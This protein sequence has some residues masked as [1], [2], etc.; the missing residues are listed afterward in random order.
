MR[1]ILCFIVMLQFCAVGFSDLDSSSV[2][3]YTSP[4]EVIVEGLPL[5]NGRLG[6]TVLGRPELDGIF[7]NDDT[8][9]S[10]EP[11]NTADGYIADVRQNFDEVVNLLK[12][13]KYRQAEEITDKT[14]LGR[15]GQPYQ[16]LGKMW[17]EFPG[18]KQVEDYQRKLDLRDAT[19]EVSYTHDGVKYS[20]EYFCSNPD[21]VFV[22]RLSASQKG[23][24]SFNVRLSSPH[25]VACSKV[26]DNQL[27]I[28]GQVPGFV[29]ERTIEFAEDRGLTEMRKY[30]ELFTNDG[31]RKTDKRVLYGDEVDGLGMFFE[32]R[33]EV[34]LEGGKLSYKDGA[35]EVK[36]ADEALV[37]FSVASSFNGFDKSPSREGRDYKR[38]NDTVLN[39]VGKSTYEVLLSRH[40]KDYRKL[41][42]RVELK[43]PEGKNS[44]LTTDKRIELYQDG[45]DEAL[46]A[47]LFNYGRYL[48]IAGSRE[49]TQPLNL[50]GIWNDN[51]NPPWGSAYTVNINLEMNYWPVEVCNLSE[52]FEPLLRLTEE[53][54][55]NGRK[56]AKNSYSRRGWLA[57]HNTNLWRRC[58]SID[59]SSRFA[60]WPMCGAWLCQ[61][62]WEHY[63]YTQDREYLQRVW[64][65]M[66]GAAEFMLDWMIENDEGYLLTPVSTSPENS[67]VYGDGLKA[68]VSQGSTM[69]MALIRDLFANCLQ[70]AEV[71]G[72]KTPVIAEI[73]KASAKLR[74]YQIGKHGQLQEWSKDWDM[75]KD[76]HRH[77]SHLFAV[78]PGCSITEKQPELFE[79]ARQSLE[80]RGDGGTGWSLTWKI[81]FWARFKDGNRAYKLLQNLLTPAE[82]KKP[83]V[84]TNLWDA[85]PPFQ[86]DGNFGATSGIAEMLMQSHTG[87]IE[88]LPALPDAWPK[89]SVKGLC[90]RGGFKVD[91]E[92]QDEKLLKAV[93]YSTAGK[94]CTVRYGDKSK[95]LKIK[96]GQSVEVSF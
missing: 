25:P 91:L 90:A 55:V 18:H 29:Y 84:Y 7:L 4:G 32:G 96:K 66:I 49:G 70:A 60:V 26:G 56:L 35:M 82:R 65:T 58:Q 11:S 64:P 61:H 48:I 52:C 19:A 74:P 30:P 16:P 76:K 81:N 69:D 86:I 21:D 88:L 1:Q 53:L 50:Q 59:R 63:Q 24:L 15:H 45:K 20:R 36:N 42:D 12:D 54:A 92:W 17:L 72:K 67:F 23:A 79:A 73:K 13:G 28:S 89:G 94:P 9:Y 80:Y 47:L 44:A 39:A 8:L 77:V 38:A 83:G 6:A 31:T 41:Y 62:L 51:V 57:Y 3:Y 5:G 43:L 93:I 68:S 10:G 37:L 34:R 85:H 27:S 33:L 40:V 71:L 75:I 46:A 22:I 14:W 95:E 87:C 78:H 2:L